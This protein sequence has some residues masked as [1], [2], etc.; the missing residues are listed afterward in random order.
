MVDYSHTSE[1][2]GKKAD[3]ASYAQEEHKAWSGIQK[4]KPK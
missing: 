4:E 2:G 3:A 1:T